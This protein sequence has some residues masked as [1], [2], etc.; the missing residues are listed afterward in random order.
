M[1]FYGNTEW[2]VRSTSMEFM[3]YAGYF[4]ELNENLMNF[5]LT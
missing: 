1:S 4:N 3:Q 5:Q 2:K